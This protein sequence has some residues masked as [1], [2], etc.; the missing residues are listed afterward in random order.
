ML[1]HVDRSVR[2]RWVQRHGRVGGATGAVGCALGRANTSGATR[3]V[4]C[5]GGT[6]VGRLT[7]DVGRLTLDA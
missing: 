3:S 1:G 4:R 6:D 2:V 7:L 5:G